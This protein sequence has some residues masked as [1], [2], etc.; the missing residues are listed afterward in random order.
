LARKP[1]PIAGQFKSERRDVS[2]D[3]VRAFEYF[4]HAG[5]TWYHHLLSAVGLFDFSAA[6]GAA[7][8]PY[9]IGSHAGSFGVVVFR[10][11]VAALS[12][13]VTGSREWLS[14]GSVTL[15]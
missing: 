10:S 11:F 8:V 2:C 6:L 4:D 5:R 3:I 12:E 1:T 14:Q 15:S 7:T 9:P 13:N